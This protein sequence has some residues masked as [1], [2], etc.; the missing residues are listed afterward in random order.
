MEDG[1]DVTRGNLIE[2]TD[3]EQAHEDEN[4]D[5]EVMGPPK[6]TRGATRKAV[7][8]QTRITRSYGKLQLI[9]LDDDHTSILPTCWKLRVVK[10]K[11]IVD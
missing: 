7:S 2:F 8:Q 6:K 10:T 11:L 4:Q 5:T 3:T 9:D 1:V